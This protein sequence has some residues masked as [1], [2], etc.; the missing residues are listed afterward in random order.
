MARHLGLQ[1]KLAS[2]SRVGTA[3]IAACPPC[4]LFCSL[5]VIDCTQIGCFDSHISNLPFTAFGTLDAVFSL[6]H[7]RF[8]PP[9][10]DAFLGTGR[11]SKPPD[12]S[13]GFSVRLLSM[14]NWAPH[15]RF[16]GKRG[17]QLVWVLLLSIAARAQT[18]ITD[19]T[20]NSPANHVPSAASSSLFESPRAIGDCGCASDAAACAIQQETGP[21][22]SFSAPAEVDNGHRVL[23]RKFI[24]FHSLNT[25]AMVADIESTAHA[26][27]GKSGAVELNP[28]FGPHPTRARMYGI[29]VPV[30]A[31]T[32]FLSHRAKKI[33]PRRRL[34]ELAPAMT[35]AIHA[36]AVTNNLV[37]AHP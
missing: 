25:L 8:C 16:E 19:S 33:A 37:A 6:G 24:V 11:V 9:I 4:A 30:N 10:S 27:A 13:D 18:P 7:P 23:D 12:R 5:S 2:N 29:G 34:W 14:R 20:N 1:L 31:F 21:N 35:M 36:G 22:A 17:L 28:L 15:R 3:Y 32:L 26:L